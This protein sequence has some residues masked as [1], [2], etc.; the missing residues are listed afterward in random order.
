MI[1]NPNRRKLSAGLACVNLYAG[2]WGEALRLVPGMVFFGVIARWAA[3]RAPDASQVR[4]ASRG[5]AGTRPASQCRSDQNQ[6]TIWWRQRTYR[7]PAS[8]I[9][10]RKIKYGI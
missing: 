6:R 5:S 2:G 4:I 7:L 10:S 8:L 1:A 3:L 9:R